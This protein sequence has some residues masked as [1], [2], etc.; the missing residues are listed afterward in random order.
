MGISKKLGPRELL[1]AGLQMTAWF[2]KLPASS[3]QALHSTTQHTFQRLR[4][5]IMQQSNR[6]HCADAATDGYKQLGRQRS[7]N[8]HHR[9]REHACADS[10]EPE[11]LTLEAGFSKQP[12]VEHSRCHLEVAWCAAERWLMAFAE[13]GL[14]P[15]LVPPPHCQAYNT[16]GE[17]TRCAL[18]SCRCS[19]CFYAEA[20]AAIM[21]L[22]RV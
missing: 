16:A 21:I 18:P 12:S 9:H 8:G 20:A 1:T 11:S 3:A 6:E 7:A 14:Q 2:S 10:T 22:R 13:Q 4:A 19:F 15:L 5:S 17:C